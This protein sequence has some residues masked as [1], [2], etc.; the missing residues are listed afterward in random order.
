MRGEQLMFT[1]RTIIKS[2]A[3]VNPSMS[4][5]PRPCGF[6]LIELLVVLAIVALLATIAVPRYFQTIDIAKET[7]LIDNLRNVRETIDK[8]YGDTGRY[9]ETLTELV[10]KKYLRALPVDPLTESTATWII[11]PPE[12][13]LKGGI[14]D[15]RSGASG[16]TRDGKLLGVL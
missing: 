10:D 7:V 8:F 3:N 12:D 1:N 5:V 14:L 16:Q 13:P 11:I 15:I 6:T 4:S 9:P 2:A